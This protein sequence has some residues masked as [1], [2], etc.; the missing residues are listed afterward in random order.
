MSRRKRHSRKYQK[1]EEYYPRLNLRSLRNLI[2]QMETSI[3]EADIQTSFKSPYSV[4]LK[5]TAKTYQVTLH[6]R[7]DPEFL[8]LS[9]E[10]EE[11]IHQFILKHWDEASN[12]KYH[13]LLKD[14]TY[15]DI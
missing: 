6:I 8:S 3:N 15:G 11:I 14:K 9:R 10:L 5:E 13:S 7:K 12:T 4:K 2:K 1:L